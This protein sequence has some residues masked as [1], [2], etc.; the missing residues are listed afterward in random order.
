MVVVGTDERRVEGMVALVVSV[1]LEPTV[2]VVVVVVLPSSLLSAKGSTF[3]PTLGAP[4][5][6]PG[7]FAVAADAVA[8][9]IASSTAPTVS[10][11]EISAPRRTRRRRR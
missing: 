9:P 11:L 3:E 5:L 2:L 4:S 8:S 7:I 10:A 1:G 6:T